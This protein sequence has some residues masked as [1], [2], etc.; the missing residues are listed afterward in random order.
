MSIAEIAKECLD[1][2]AKVPEGDRGLPSQ[3]TVSES[4][5]RFKLWANNIGALQK[6]RSSLDS[7]L[8]ASSLAKEVKTLLS[9]LGETLYYL[10]SPDAD[11]DDDDDAA[12]EA[13]SANLDDDI[14][15]DLLEA[16]S[17][18]ITNLFKTSVLIRNA[19][20][21]DPWK[22]ILALPAWDARPMVDNV[23]QRCPKLKHEPWL[24][25]RLGLANARRKQ[26]FRYR[27]EHA[28]KLAND[29]QEHGPPA[30]ETD[31]TTFYEGPQ[32]DQETRH[33][34]IEDDT[35]SVTSFATSVDFGNEETMT[36]PAAPDGHKERRH[37]EHL[38]FF[39]LPKL[40]EMQNETQQS[41]S[42]SEEEDLA[43]GISQAIEE[44]EDGTGYARRSSERSE[45]SD[46]TGVLEEQHPRQHLGP[47]TKPALNEFSH[48]VRPPGTESE[49]TTSHEPREGSV[50]HPFELPP[51]QQM[52][53]QPGSTP[54][55]P[56][57]TPP[58]RA[59]TPPP[60]LVQNEL[61]TSDPFRLPPLQQMFGQPGSTPPP[62]STPPPRVSTPPPHLLQSSELS[63]MDSLE[64][65]EET[66]AQ[67]HRLPPPPAIQLPQSPP[68]T[69]ADGTWERDVD[70]SHP[71][72]P[73]IPR[74]PLPPNMRRSSESYHGD[75]VEHRTFSTAK[76][77]PMSPAAALDSEYAGGR[78]VRNDQ[79]AGSFASAVGDYPFNDEWA[80]RVSSY[81]SDQEVEM[82]LSL[83][84][85]H[86]TDFDAI[87]RQMGSKS[88]SMVKN[89]FDRT[90]TKTSNLEVVA[91]EADGRKRR[92]RLGQPLPQRDQ[93]ASSEPSSRPAA[94]PPPT[95]EAQ[96]TT[97][98]AYTSFDHV[99]SLQSAYDGGT[100]IDLETASS[101]PRHQP[102]NDNEESPG[103]VPDLQTRRRQQHMLAEQ[104]QHQVL[105]NQLQ[106]EQLA[107]DRALM[108]RQ[109]QNPMGVMQ[110]EQD[111]SPQQQQAWQQQAQQQ[112]VQQQQLSSYASAES[113]GETIGRLRVEPNNQKSRR[114]I[115]PRSRSRRPPTEMKP[116]TKSDRRNQSSPSDEDRA[117]FDKMLEQLKVPVE[118]Q[119]ERADDSA[120]DSPGKE[121]VQNAPQAG[122]K[123]FELPGSQPD[124]PYVP[125][126]VKSVRVHPPAGQTRDG[127]RTSKNDLGRY[128]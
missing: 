25:W 124:E 83:L 68:G 51:L 63:R 12:E 38:S 16:A 27:E 107:R 3:Q 81:W 117:G 90:K 125:F 71:P 109:Q 42:S 60:Y 20:T 52:L 21:R 91:R 45:S 126:P 40:Q 67:P 80:D 4:L 85:K 99:K 22:R 10:T 115:A 11:D 47:N 82:F 106:A 18:T 35:T 49:L 89:Y 104:L 123:V 101:S 77:D 86:G 112:Q 102:A 55:P 119:E 13:S 41:T 57:S 92:S 7:R 103:Y 97:A 111:L 61:T 108:N 87:A 24:A 53:G 64:S 28:A 17:I 88:P 121:T 48:S 118:E 72:P 34:D 30:T 100:D 44:T 14:L 114:R 105:V 58:L 6:G 19:P 54:Q 33:H 2:F 15:S 36:I 69:S 73:P 62:V 96:S 127:P 122:S 66:A 1:R 120:R 65:R 74:P 116:A 43:P 84:E 93:L 78:W 110:T 98:P 26:F 75:R 37:M 95:V 32:H 8:G 128:P 70:V 9:E 50:A 29:V 5:G 31:P 59:P 94:R 76:L 23:V 113:D 79:E 56:V 46:P 39:A